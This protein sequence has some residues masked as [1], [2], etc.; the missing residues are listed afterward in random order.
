MSQT[1]RQMLNAA[2]ITILM[3]GEMLTS[4]LCQEEPNSL[5][6]FRQVCLLGQ[7]ETQVETEKQR[8]FFSLSCRILVKNNVFSPPSGPV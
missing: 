8:K 2:K 7:T 4:K 3:M 6:L 1:G 5:F